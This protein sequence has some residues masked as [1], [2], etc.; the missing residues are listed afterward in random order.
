M[1]GL[2][3][4]SVA[5]PSHSLLKS[6]PDGYL[7]AEDR[8]VPAFSIVSLIRLV[9]RLSKM[10]ED[11]EPNT[12]LS[13]LTLLYG[14]FD[15]IAQPRRKRRMMARVCYDIAK[16]ARAAN[17]AIIVAWDCDFLPPNLETVFTIE[18]ECQRTIQG[19]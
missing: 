19:M 5:S 4:S 16:L 2:Y 6:M 3:V 14:I 9:H 18:A 12:I 15:T 11:T 8:F 1:Q 17:A 10:R 13:C 7:P